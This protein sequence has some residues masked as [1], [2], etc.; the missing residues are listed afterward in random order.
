MTRTKKLSSYFS[1]TKKEKTT[2][3]SWIKEHKAKTAGI[4]ILA[5]IAAFVIWL[6]ISFY[7]A[8]TGTGLSIGQGGSAPVS[9]MAEDTAGY[10]PSASRGESAA[11][12]GDSS[13]K[14]QS[15]TNIADR[16][17]IKT[18]DLSMVVENADT[19]A[20]RIT[21]IA[22]LYRGYVDNVHIYESGEDTKKGSVTI[23]VPSDSFDQAVEDIKEFAAKVTSERL[24][25][26]DVTEQIIDLEA[27]LKTLRSAEAGYRQLLERAGDVEDILKVRERLDDVRSD[28]ERMEAQL[29]SLTRRVDMSTITVNLTAKADVEVFGVIWTPI[30]KIKAGFNN[31]LEDLAAFA[32]TV[33]AF[34]FALPIIILWILFLGLVL[35]IIFRI[36]RALWRKANR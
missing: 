13:S 21:G 22:D 11:Y 20:D 3:A 31:M 2:P 25:T 34:I 30:Q 9:G 35:Y 15:V 27:R 36:A 26:R 8:Y 7:S 4:V 19:A 16:Q 28:I 24:G 29:E 14:E 12:D 5:I 23:R 33:I 6:G 10:A 18:A 32:N 17:V 1:R